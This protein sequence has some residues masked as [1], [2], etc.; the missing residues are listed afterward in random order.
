MKE[1]E[2]HAPVDL[3]AVAGGLFD[4]GLVDPGLPVDQ[5]AVAV[6]R[7]DLELIEPR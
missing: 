5:R 6:E 3:E 4:K 2:E 7:E 1:G